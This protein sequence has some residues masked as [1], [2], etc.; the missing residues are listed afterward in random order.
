MLFRSAVAE[1]E[2]LFPFLHL[3]K[4]LS[5]TNKKP[6]SAVYAGILNAIRL[7]ILSPDGASDFMQAALENVGAT[8]TPTRAFTNYMSQLT[9]RDYSLKRNGKNRRSDTEAIVFALT[10][11]IARKH[12]LGIPMDQPSLR[13]GVVEFARRR[14]PGIERLFEIARDLKGNGNWEDEQ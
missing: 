14:E 4:N 6:P 8:G 2:P 10:T 1:L 3:T 11:S 13:K 7:G 12:S 9:A 5:T